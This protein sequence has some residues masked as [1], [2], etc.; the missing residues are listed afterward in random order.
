ML[1]YYFN[2]YPN[3]LTFSIQSVNVHC[4]GP[5]G[6]GNLYSMKISLDPSYSVTRD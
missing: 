6:E 4:E 5:N 2:I 3:F 1:L